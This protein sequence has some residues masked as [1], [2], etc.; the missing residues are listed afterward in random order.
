MPGISD[1]SHHWFL[2]PKS[3]VGSYG[4]KFISEYFLTDFEYFPRC[5]LWNFSHRGIPPF[6]LQEMYKKLLPQPEISQSGPQQLS[7][8][9][10]KI[11]K[12]SKKNLFQS[13]WIP[14]KYFSV[15]KGQFLQISIFLQN[16]PEN[17]ILQR[18]SVHIPGSGEKNPWTQNLLFLTEN[19]PLTISPN[20]IPGQNPNLNF[21]S[22]KY[23]NFTFPDFHPS[24]L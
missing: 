13:G 3:K 15:R 4:T 17:S 24:H 12:N 6:I 10:P 21:I 19:Y 5:K 14:V 9:N 16:W 23:P 7:I 2:F 8:K 11:T 1:W 18:H 20:S 22:G